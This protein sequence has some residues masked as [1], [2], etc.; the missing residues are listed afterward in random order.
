MLPDGTGTLAGR[1]QQPPGLRFNA[2][3]AAAQKSGGQQPP[4]RTAACESASP[5][6]ALVA[7]ARQRVGKL[8]HFARQSGFLDPNRCSDL[9]PVKQLDN[10]TRSHP[11]TA[12]TARV[13]DCPF[14][15]GAVNV[16]APRMRTAVLVCSPCNH[17][18]RVTIG[19]RP[20]ASTGRTSPVGRRLLKT[21]P[22]GIPAP[23]LFATA[24]LPNGVA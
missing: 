6:V 15:R 18:I 3:C 17:M 14:L 16:D 19:S 9:D 8:P 4:D 24:S 23:I 13:A 1:A 10:V 5:A 7:A 12:V 11:D 20:G 2:R 21:I 22:G